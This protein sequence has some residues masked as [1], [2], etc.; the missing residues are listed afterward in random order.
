MTIGCYFH[1]SAPTQAIKLHLNYIYAL[2]FPDYLIFCTQISSIKA[3]LGIVQLATELQR[4][5]SWTICVGWN[6]A[7]PGKKTRTST[8]VAYSRSAPTIIDHVWMALVKTITKYHYRLSIPLIA[9]TKANHHQSPTSL[10]RIELAKASFMVGSMVKGWAN[11][12]C[13]AIHFWLNSC[14]NQLIWS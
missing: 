6:P 11:W 13:Q 12:W 3:H 8:D 1:G 4:K 10:L 5:K 2:C 9:S 7:S 14:I